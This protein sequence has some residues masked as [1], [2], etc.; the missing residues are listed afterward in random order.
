LKVAQNFN[1]LELGVFCYNISTYLIMQKNYFKTHLD[2]IDLRLA[3][4]IKPKITYLG[5]AD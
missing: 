4:T 2:S 5:F 1:P 3:D